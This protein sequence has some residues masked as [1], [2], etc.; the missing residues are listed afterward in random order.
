MNEL[1]Q[2]YRPGRAL[3]DECASRPVRGFRRGRF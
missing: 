3:E 1:A 2:V